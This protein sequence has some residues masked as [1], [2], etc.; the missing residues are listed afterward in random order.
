V[1]PYIIT[2]L[3]EHISDISLIKK[4]V[5]LG[6]STL[7]NLLNDEELWHTA[8]EILIGWGFRAL[9]VLES[10]KNTEQRMLDEKQ[11]EEEIALALIVQNRIQDIIGKIEK[12]MEIRTGQGY[13][14]LL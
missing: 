1:D 8:S 3:Q 9:S 6:I 4:L 12:Q 11:N 10:K 2:K 5:N 7:I 13:T 14:L